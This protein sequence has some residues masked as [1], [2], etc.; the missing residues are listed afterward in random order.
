MEL[1]LIQENIRVYYVEAHA[2][3]EGIAA[4][5]ERLFSEF[6]E[7]ETRRVF[8]ISRPEKGKIVYRAAVEISGSEAFSPTQIMVIPQGKYR[9][10]SVPN[11]QQNLNQVGLAFQSLTAQP[12]IDPNGYCLEYYQ[13]AS[14]VLCMVRLS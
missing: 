12:D 13:G 1:L 9:V 3:P 10:I 14:D 4:A 6:P 11:Y 8:G 5:F 2:F 7:H